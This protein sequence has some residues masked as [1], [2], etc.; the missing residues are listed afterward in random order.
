MRL[1]V[2]ALRQ[3]R[4]E[5]EIELLAVGA[6][7]VELD[8]PREVVLVAQLDAVV[9]GDDGDAALQHRDRADEPTIDEHVGVAD[10]R[11]DEEDRVV[12]GDLRAGLLPAT[13]RRERET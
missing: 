8:V 4:R 2:T 10:V 6:L 3:D 7:E 13:A 11:L 12:G 5:I 9:A 1:G